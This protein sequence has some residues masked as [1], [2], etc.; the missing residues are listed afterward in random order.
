[1]TT[2]T[3][4]TTQN[5]T[6]L[7]GKVGGDAYNINGAELIINTDTRYGPNT[8]PTIGPTG[9]ITVSATLGGTLTIEGFS[10]RLIPYNNGTGNV[11]PS[12][13]IL[14]QG[15]VTCELL[16]AMSLRTGGTVTG[17]G[18]TLPTTGWLKVRGV[19]GV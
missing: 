9:N 4:T 13:T 10:V 15:G 11:P 14:T 12:G 3:I 2:Y 16:C 19:T 1:M 18:A 7:A 5:M 8:S 6:Q 17:S